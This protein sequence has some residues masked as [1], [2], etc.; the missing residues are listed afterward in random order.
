MLRLCRDATRAKL[1]AL[2]KLSFPD[3]LELLNLSGNALTRIAGVV[4][5]KSLTQLSINKL[6]PV[7]EGDVATDQDSVLEEFEVRQTDATVFANIKTTLFDVVATVKATCSDTRAKRVY[8]RDTM[9]CVLTDDAFKEKY[10]DTS[11]GTNGGAAN[12]GSGGGASGSQPLVVVDE[13]FDQSRSWFL[14]VAA[15]ALGGFVVCVF[16]V[17]LCRACGRGFGFRAKEEDDDEKQQRQQQEL[18]RRDRD[19]RGRDADDDDEPDSKAA[20]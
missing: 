6:A 8:V 3:A 20:V 5:P 11:S 14:I 19:G 4:F 12:G 7:V 15:V 13:N 17:A 9:L 10:G 2:E 16:G 1:T 18:L